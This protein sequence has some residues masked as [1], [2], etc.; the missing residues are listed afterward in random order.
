MWLFLFFYPIPS[1]LAVSP[2]CSFRMY[3]RLLSIA[4]LLLS[5][6]PAVLA[7]LHLTQETQVSLITEG[8]GEALYAGFGHSAIWIF[9]PSQGIDRLYNYGTF[10][11][12]DPLFY[13]KFVRGKLLYMLSVGRMEWAFYGSQME[14]RSLTMQELSLSE[15]QKNQLYQFLEK[16][17]LPENKFYAYDFFYDNCSTR[18]RDAFQQVLGDSL[19][20]QPKSDREKSFRD[21]TDEYLGSKKWEDLGIDL[22]L[23][24]PTDKIATPSQYMFLPDYLMYNFDWAQVNRGNG[25][26]PLVEQKRLLLNALPMLKENPWVQ[27]AP[28]LWTFFG[29]IALLSLLQVLKNNSN[30]WPDFL[31]FLLIGL[32]G[33]LMAGVWFLTDHR[34]AAGN[35]NLLWALPTHLPVAFLLL[36]R[37][38]NAHLRY[39]YFFT[40]CWT[41]LVL[42]AWAWLPQNL[43]EA[44]LPLPLAVLLR[45]LV[46]L[47][48]DKQVRA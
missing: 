41:G 14:G 31:V 23:G 22:L 1:Y 12:S 8:P 18:I 39:Y 10:D 28:V 40:A 45:S 32:L 29:I 19:H 47:R 30:R 5:P 48:I 35:L 24:L 4:Y 9:D 17:A 21:M 11:V 46:R 34:Q 25:F 13:A 36:S 43:H 7:Q 6:I 38:L 16:N 42:L 20:F 2:G 33:S 37:K 44:A 3:L 15:T 27:P 26:E